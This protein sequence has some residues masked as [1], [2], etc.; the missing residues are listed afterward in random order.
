MSQQMDFGEIHSDGPPPSY[1]GY[2]GVPHDRGY[3]AS[4][5]GQKLSGY[6]V[7]RTASAGQRL[8]LAIVSLIFL[9]IFGVIGLGIASNGGLI[10]A[11]PILLVL[12][13]FYTAVVIINVVFNR[14]G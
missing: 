3:S 1:S 7:G 9:A 10:V 12:T 11:V 5:Y 14:R 2:T 8:A 13:L 6:S 4:S